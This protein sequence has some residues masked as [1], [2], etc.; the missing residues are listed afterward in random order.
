MP[1]FVRLESLTYGVSGD[2]EDFDAGGVAEI[3]PGSRSA[4]GVR[5]P[6]RWKSTPEGS[7]NV[8]RIKGFCDPS[9]VENRRDVSDPRVR[10][11]T[12]G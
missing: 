11:A 3:S 8:R 2:V 4:P 1:N 5:V 9:G 6:E 7:Q 12:R 10:C